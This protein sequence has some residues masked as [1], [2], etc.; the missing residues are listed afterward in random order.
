VAVAAEGGI[1]TAAAR[2]AVAVAAVLA[3]IR[4]ADPVLISL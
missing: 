3:V 4:I 1:M 2:V